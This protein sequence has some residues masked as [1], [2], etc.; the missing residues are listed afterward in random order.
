MVGSAMLRTVLS[1]T[2]T[3]RLTTSTAR[4]AQRRGCPSPDVIHAFALLSMPLL[5]RAPSA[6]S[7]T[8]P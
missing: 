8:A 2:T 5:A 7:E 4:M 3:S 6:Y 1:R